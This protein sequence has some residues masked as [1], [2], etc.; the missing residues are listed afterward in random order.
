VDPILIKVQQIPLLQQIV[1]LLQCLLLEVVK[2][3]EVKDGCVEAERGEKV[4]GLKRGATDV[5]ANPASVN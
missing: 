3:A 2:R 4:D 1:K 5:G